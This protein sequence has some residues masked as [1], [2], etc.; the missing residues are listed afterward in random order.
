MLSLILHASHQQQPEKALILVVSTS[1]YLVIYEAHLGVLLVS[2][3]IFMVSDQNNCR[4]E[5]SNELTDDPPN[6]IFSKDI[7]TG[8]IGDDEDAFELNK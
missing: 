2:N 1:L 7:Q 3:L 4:E 8:I 6:Q 5:A